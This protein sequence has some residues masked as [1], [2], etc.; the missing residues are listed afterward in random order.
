MLRNGTHSTQIS[1]LKP[2][3]FCRMMLRAEIGELRCNCTS[4]AGVGDLQANRDLSFSSVCSI[5]YVA[6]SCCFLGAGPESFMKRVLCIRFPNWSI[7][8]LWRELREQMPAATALAVHTPF[9]P[10]TDST[11]KPGDIDEDTRYVR[12]VFPSARGGPA[13]VAVSMDAWSQGVR[14]GMPLAD[15]CS[16]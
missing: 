2:R 7:Q 6:Q 13:I 14:P 1:R 8:C 15:L 9:A 16:I 5:Q 10:Q 12:A 4:S 11:A 3:N